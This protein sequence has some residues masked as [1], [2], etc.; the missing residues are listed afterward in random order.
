MI[1][2]RV[3]SNEWISTSNEQQVKSFASLRVGL[4]MLSI[5]FLIKQFNR[6]SFSLQLYSCLRKISLKS[7]KG[8][9]KNIVIFSKIFEET[10]SKQ[11][12]RWFQEKIQ[13]SLLLNTW[14][15]KTGIS[16]LSRFWGS[17]R[18]FV[19]SSLYRIICPH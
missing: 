15:M 17:F 11:T 7:G 18:K 1:L 9:K 3:T 19:N 6:Q 12:L 4:L 5:G 13:H 14:I 16:K 8:L 2:Q 10:M